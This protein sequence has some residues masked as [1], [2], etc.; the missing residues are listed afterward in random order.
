MEATKA[1][2]PVE[3]LQP[4]NLKRSWVNGPG[5]RQTTADPKVR[6]LGAKHKGQA[7]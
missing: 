1:L 2:S 7:G 3:R 4:L 6:D 5:R